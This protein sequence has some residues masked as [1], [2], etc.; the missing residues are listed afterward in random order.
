M[1]GTTSY[2]LSE[3]RGTYLKSITFAVA[4]SFHSLLEG[5]ALGVQDK[6]ERIVTLFLSLLLHKCIE[7][8]SV[9]LQVSK[10]NSDKLKAVVSTIFIYSLMTPVGEVLG[11]FLQV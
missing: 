2:A 3:E 7:A 8:F 9:G 1:E 10:G 6:P 5:F 11:A 4:I